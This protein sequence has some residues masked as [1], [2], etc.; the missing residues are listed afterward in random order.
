MNVEPQTTPDAGP[1]GGS[2]AWGNADWIWLCISV[3]MTIAIEGFVL[4]TTIVSCDEFGPNP[5]LLFLPMAIMP[6]VGLVQSINRKCIRK[7][8]LRIVVALAILVAVIIGTVRI[9][10]Y[11][12]NEFW[13]DID[14]SLVTYLVEYI[15]CA[16]LIRKFFSGNR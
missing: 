5:I 8:P 12:E 15:S 7:F 4:W 10:D 6:V 9:V 14:H 3:A 1:S 2:A 16:V 13:I 11:L